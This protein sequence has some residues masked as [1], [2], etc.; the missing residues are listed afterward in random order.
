M[1]N[2]ILCGSLQNIMRAKRHISV[3]YVVMRRESLFHQHLTV[4]RMAYI[5]MMLVTGIITRMAW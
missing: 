1:E 4:P 3:M 5:W 2:G